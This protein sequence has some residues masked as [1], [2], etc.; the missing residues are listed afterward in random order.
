MNHNEPNFSPED[1]HFSL[2]AEYWPQLFLGVFIASGMIIL[3]SDASIGWMFWLPPA[4]VA[5]WVLLRLV[6][7][8]N[9]TK[10]EQINHRQLELEAQRR[11]LER[12]NKKPEAVE[13]KA[14]TPATAQ[15]ET[16]AAAPVQEESLVIDAAPAPFADG[17]DVIVLW[18]SETGNAEGLAEMTA[19]R[20]G[21]KGIAARAMDMGKVTAGQLCNVQQLLVITSTWGDGEPPSNAIELWETLK[22]KQVDLK[23]MKF[24]VLVLG[25]GDTAY[26]QFCQ[27]GKDFDSYLEGHG[28]QR[29]HPRVDCDLDYEANF[30]SWLNGVASKVSKA[31]VA[32]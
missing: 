4:M 27:C 19:T 6:F 14:D 2:I 5:G 3:T 23:K 29:I 1:D 28:A 18:G 11:F 17:Q 15:A 16:A 12:A 31:L 21:E 7:N 26:P 24:S 20:L 30:E 22:N 25:L 9:R 10:P 13:K 32:A 8:P